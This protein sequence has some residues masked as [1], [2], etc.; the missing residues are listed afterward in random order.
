MQIVIELD[1][2]EYRDWVD[3][4]KPIFINRLCGALYHGIPLPKGHGRLIDGD[5]LFSDMQNGIYAGNYEEGY[6][7]Y[8][9]ILNMDDCLEEVEVAD[10]IIPADNIIK[11]P[12]CG[13]EQY[14][15]KEYCMDCGAKLEE[16]E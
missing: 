7:K 9:H 10:T 13:I 8:G 15:D 3:N 5:K 11:C 2:E 12:N 6:E 14:N 16:S 4:G 1:E